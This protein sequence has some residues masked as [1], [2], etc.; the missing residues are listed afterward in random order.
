MTYDTRPRVG[1]IDERHYISDTSPKQVQ[2]YKP[3]SNLTY[4]VIQ[5][6][7][8]LGCGPSPPQQQA[9]AV[10]LQ[11]SP[12]GGINWY[13]IETFSF[14]SATARPVY[15]ALSVPTAARTAATRVR[16]WQPSL[17]G[18]FLE[19]WAMDQVDGFVL[20]FCLLN[21][22]HQ[23]TALPLVLHIE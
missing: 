5:F 11:Y 2:H 12:N 3:I 10:L 19:E 16:W 7:L 18:T 17:N 9:E 20:L 4:R 15:V 13:T 22:F 21:Q 8:R 23:L 6:V 14:G 1:T